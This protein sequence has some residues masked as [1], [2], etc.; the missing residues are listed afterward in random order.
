MTARSH[1][2]VSRH[3]ASINF[4]KMSWSLAQPE[5]PHTEPQTLQLSEDKIAHIVHDEHG[6]LRA[7]HEVDLARHKKLGRIGKLTT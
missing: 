6:A 2:Q 4:A 3:D 1:R 5:T 7:A